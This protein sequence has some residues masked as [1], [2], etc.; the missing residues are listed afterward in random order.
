MYNK[1]NVITYVPMSMYLH[2]EIAKNVCPLADD[3]NTKDKQ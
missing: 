1:H 3:I 2:L